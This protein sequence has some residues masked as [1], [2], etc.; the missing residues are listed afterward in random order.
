[1]RGPAGVSRPDWEIFG[2]LAA[3]MGGDLGFETLEELREESARLLDPKPASVRTDAWTGTGRPQLLGDLT[4]FTYPLLV[5]EG[6][7]SQDAVELK[8]AL[9]HGPFAELHP[10]DAEKRGVA[11]GQRVLVRTDAGQAELPV[12]VTAD[13][14]AGAVFVPFNQPGLAANVLLRRGFVEPAT[15]EVSASEGDA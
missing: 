4:L 6:R 10:E 9:G 11:D 7:L 2:G 14:A 1:V 13:V 15:V 12:R 3:A 5:D 8:A